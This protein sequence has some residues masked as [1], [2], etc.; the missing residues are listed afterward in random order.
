MGI[1]TLARVKFS[2]IVWH[3]KGFESGNDS[4]YLYLGFD[5]LTLTVNLSYSDPIQL[6]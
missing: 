2:A 6:H 3:L 5:T 1:D 4:S